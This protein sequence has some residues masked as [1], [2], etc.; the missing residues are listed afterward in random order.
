MKKFLSVCMC[1]FILTIS[2]LTY[3]PTCV[4]AADDF[5]LSTSEGGNILLM[6]LTE[7][8]IIKVI[9]IMLIMKFCFVILLLLI[10]TGL[11]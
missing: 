4:Y 5:T 3:F 9:F 10:I 11:M 6:R 8:L 7:Q 2:V 1:I